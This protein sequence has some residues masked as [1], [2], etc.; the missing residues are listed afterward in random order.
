MLVAIFVVIFSVILVLY[1]LSLV[2]RNQ[3]EILT[4]F[5]HLN[6]DDI[7]RVNRKC[8]YYYEGLTEGDLM[9]RYLIE[10]DARNFKSYDGSIYGSTIC[11]TLRKEL[12]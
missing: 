9:K 11:P 1:Y 4:L 10:S 3:T 5:S 6:M 8:A 7:L 12:G 2:E